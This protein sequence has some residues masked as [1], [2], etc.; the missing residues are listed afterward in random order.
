MWCAVMRLALDRRSPAHR[1]RIRFS[2]AQLGEVGSA[3]D[4]RRLPGGAAQHEGRLFGRALVLVAACRLLV[5]LQQHAVVDVLQL[6]THRHT[7][8]SDYHASCRNSVVI[9]Y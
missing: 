2:G 6:Q 9:R 1:R 3:A 5:L 4:V 7:T 8:N